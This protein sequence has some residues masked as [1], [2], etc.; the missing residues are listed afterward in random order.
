MELLNTSFKP[1]PCAHII[2]PFLDALL[3]FYREEGLRADEVTKIV[4]PIAEYMIS[5]CCEPTDMKT[6]PRRITMAA[7]LSNILWARLYILGGLVSKLVRTR[8][9]EIQICWPKWI[10]WN[11]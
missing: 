3:Y 8:T 1:Y 10:K 4:C 5:I 6:R 11:T 2:H 7:S 9:F